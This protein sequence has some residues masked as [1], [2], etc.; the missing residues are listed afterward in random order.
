MNVWE[1]LISFRGRTVMLEWCAGVP[2]IAQEMIKLFEHDE[3]CLLDR[4]KNYSTAYVAFMFCRS[5]VAC[6]GKKKLEDTFYNPSF[7]S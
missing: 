3:L 5:T 7:S 4:Q 2:Y 6:M 1:Q